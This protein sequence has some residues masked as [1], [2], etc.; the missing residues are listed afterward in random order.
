MSAELTRADKIRL[1]DDIA[2]IENLMAR[3]QYS[4]TAGMSTEKADLF[5]QETPGARL[6][7]PL[8]GIYDGIESIRSFYTGVGRF[9]Q[10]D[11]RGHLNVHTLTTPVIEVAGDGKTAQGVWLSPGVATMPDRALWAWVKYG[12]DFVREAGVWRIWHFRVYRIFSVAPGES[13][14]QPPTPFSPKLPPELLP[15]RPADGDYHYSPDHEALHM[16][17]PPEPYDTWD[18]ELAYVK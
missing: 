14:A 16:P 10:G 8:V 12:I 5:A 13:W 4:D 3:Y 9:V 15:D 17:A 2:Q 18:E 6:E 11:R 1:L 7:L